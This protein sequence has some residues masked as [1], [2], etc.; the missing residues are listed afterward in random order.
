M[1]IL[2]KPGATVREILPSDRDKPAEKQTVL[3][4]RVPSEAQYRQ[5]L[6]ID[7]LQRS[8]QL[9][10]FDIIRTRFGAMLESV[11]NLYFDDGTPI[12]IEKDGDGRL[13]PPCMAAIYPLVE[14]INPILERCSRL[15]EEDRKN[16]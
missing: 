8:G 6:K 10:G 11:E 1:A 15:T 5:L 4:I 7:L 14:E 16:S 12:V 3:N 13:T 2:R 9:N